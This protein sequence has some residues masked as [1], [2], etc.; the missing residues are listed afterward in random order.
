MLERVNRLSATLD[1]MNAGVSP[2]MECVEPISPA[3]LAAMPE[4]IGYVF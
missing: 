3:R 4:N 1:R 2:R